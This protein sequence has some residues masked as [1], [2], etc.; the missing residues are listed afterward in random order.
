MKRRYDVRS[1]AIWVVLS[2]TAFALHGKASN[3][4]STD[5]PIAATSAPVSQTHFAQFANGANFVSSLLLTNP[6]RT[7]TA[8][9]SVSFF[10]DEGQPLFVPL[11]GEPSAS[12]VS[13]S[14]QPLGSTTFTSDGAGDLVS[15]S[16]RVGTNI[17]VAGVV[18]F[19]FPGLGI[20]AVGEGVPLR[21]LMTPVV[22]DA[23]SGL[24][25]GIAISNTQP[26]EVKLVFSL[27]AL[28]GRE[29]GS[30][31]ASE[32]LPANGH[33][34]KFIDELFPK[35]NTANFQGTLIVTATTSGGKVAATAIQ[36]GS[37]AGEFTTLPVVAVEPAP[38]TRQLF[39]AQFANGSGWTSS[40]FLTNPLGF[41]AATG[42]LSFFDDHGNRLAVSVGGKPASARVYFNLPPQ[43]GA[44]FTTDGQG[45]LISG[46][47]RVTAGSPIG[48]VLRFAYPR[49]GIAGVDASVATSGFITPVTRSA[50]R[51]IS[52]G[53]AI[54]SVGP[55]VTVSLTLRNQNGE[56]VAGGE[57]TSQLPA[58]GYLARFI[59]D[60]FPNADAGEFEG[61]LTV[62]AE[63]GNVAGTAIQLG[64]RAGEFTTMPVTALR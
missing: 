60:L 50:A 54:T 47:A 5:A 55:P 4:G 63:G 30:G 52:T 6:S 24:N 25:T 28:D 51:N 12:S 53:V 23:S 32:R 11:N 57:A 27:R 26:G 45:R 48:G 43:G 61:T 31:S 41:F 17:P 19:S 1:V 20:A 44:V 59:E 10:N 16:A 7:E 9:G 3:A 36:L 21:A 35:A 39:F 56:P 33:L 38:T 8:S 64:S 18:R 46:S 62:T 58:N 2:L 37:S 42:E 13:F 34:A 22:R 29:V 14:I 40:L 49:L 15:G